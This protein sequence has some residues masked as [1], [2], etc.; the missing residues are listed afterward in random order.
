MSKSNTSLSI[1]DIV[2][3]HGESNG[4]P[5]SLYGK[6]IGIEGEQAQVAPN[7]IQFSDFPEPTRFP[8][9]SLVRCPTL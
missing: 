1:G 7:R 8:L 5:V 9:K 4:M 3:Y 2:V 6:I